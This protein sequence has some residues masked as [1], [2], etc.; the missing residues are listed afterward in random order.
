VS[1]GP[2]EFQ[3]ESNTIAEF[4][5]T[6]N[7]RMVQRWLLTNRRFRSRSKLEAV[8]LALETA[9]NMIAVN[10]TGE[11]AN[12]TSASSQAIAEIRKLIACVRPEE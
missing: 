10:V 4:V 7:R 8:E 12:G 11:D 1:D 5:E 9:A 2:T 3:L 6:G